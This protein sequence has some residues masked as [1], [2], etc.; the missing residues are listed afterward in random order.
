MAMIRRSRG[1]YRNF[2]FTQSDYDRTVVH[3]GSVTYTAKAE[4]GLGF[5][6]PPGPVVE[7][8][9]EFFYIQK[10]DTVTIVGGKP[11]DADIEIGIN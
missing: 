11:P 5:G 1:N 8:R 6:H 7:K 9:G 3:P 10:G 2:V 4:T